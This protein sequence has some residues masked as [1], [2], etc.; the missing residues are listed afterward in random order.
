MTSIVKQKDR[1][2][3]RLLDRLGK[4]FQVSIGLHEAEGALPHK[5]H[6]RTFNAI[7]KAGKAL[8]K[9]E[10]MAEG[11]KASR[12]A[13]LQKA[14]AKFDAR[15]MP[16]TAKARSRRAVRRA[17]MVSKGAEMTTREMRGHFGAAGAERDLHRWRAQRA[18]NIERFGDKK[19]AVPSLIE[20][21]TFHEFGFGVPRRSFIADWFDQNEM[22]AGKVLRKLAGN[23]VAGKEDLKTSLTKFSTWA[24]GQVQ[25]RIAAGIAP[26]L[27]PS[28]IR[29]KQG[30]TVPLINTGQ[31]RSSIRGRVKIQK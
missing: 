15:P 19:R 18:R 27:A 8:Q 4:N 5:Q 24:V 17:L 22:Q 12:E 14:L 2:M 7:D 1:G 20:I 16:K 30:K 25:A 28:T 29:Q 11:G 9:F 31:L 3:Q 13:R 6:E 10:G 26:P 23:H 21:A